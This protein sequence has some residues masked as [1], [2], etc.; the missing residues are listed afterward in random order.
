MSGS[1]RHAL[2][3]GAVLAC[4]TAGCES[5]KKF[6]TTMEVIQVEH[7]KD[8]KGETTKLGLELRYADCPG[9]ARRVLRAAKAF[10]ACA[11]PIKAG[12]KLMLGVYIS[13][14]LGMLSTWCMFLVKEQHVPIVFRAARIAVPVLSAL[15]MGLACLT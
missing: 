13:L 14:A 10:A 1:P 11:G 3:L 2:L 15:T 5:P 8:D 9:D 12:D 6:T 7:F 4:A